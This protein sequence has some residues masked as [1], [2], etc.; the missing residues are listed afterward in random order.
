MKQQNIVS[1]REFKQLCETSLN[2]E[3]TNLCSS[4]GKTERY[5]LI[6][7]PR[8]KSYGAPDYELLNSI[9]V[10]NQATDFVHRNTRLRKEHYI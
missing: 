6:N 8:R 10:T 5:T 4:M 7:E 2:S 1:G 9:E 3:D